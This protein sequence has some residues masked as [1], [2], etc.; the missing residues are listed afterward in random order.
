MIDLS[1]RKVVSTLPVG[2]RPRGIR[3]SSDG[4]LVFAAVS[5]STPSA[6]G[7]DESLLPPPDRAADGIAVIDTQQR[8]VRV[9]ASG[10]DPES[11]DFSRDGAQ[12]YV[13]NEDAATASFVDLRSGAIT[14]VP[15]GEEP[16]GVTTHPSGSV[17][18]VTTENDAQ[19]DVVDVSSRKR[20]SR[21]EVGKRPRS[22]TFTP[23]GS[24]AF[25]A[26]EN[27]GTITV[28]DARGHKPLKSISIKFPGARPMGSALSPDGKRLYVSLGRARAVAVIDT[29]RDEVVHIV[30]EVGAR[31]WGIGTTA[32]GRI[33][34]ANGPSNDVTIIEPT[35]WA[36]QKIPVGTFPWGVALWEPR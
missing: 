26:N 2:K 34:T 16:E 1:S 11:F 3:V 21:I 29:M 14:S 33:I 19:V 25:V 28:V 30:E 20:I 9:L 10:P 22:V 27:D 12:L 31:P 4:A 32:D 24:R 17:V 5:G 23:D 36:L 18:Y 13:S 6:P 15:V 8:S 35:T 7:Q